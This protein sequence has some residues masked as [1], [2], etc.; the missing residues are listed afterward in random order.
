MHSSLNE[1]TWVIFSALV[2]A[3][4]YLRVSRWY[5]PP[6]VDTQQSIPREWDVEL[7]I[8]RVVNRNVKPPEESRRNC[9]DQLCPDSHLSPLYDPASLNHLFI[10]QA[11]WKNETNILY[12]QF[13]WF[14]QR[15]KSWKKWL[16]QVFAM[17]ICNIS[18]KVLVHV[19]YSS[20]S[21]SVWLPFFHGTQKGD[22]FNDFLVALF[23]AITM[24][25]DWSFK[26]SKTTQKHH[27]IL[28][29][30][31]YMAHTQ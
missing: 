24:I 6:A 1:R 10:C 15:Q 12:V 11:K 31:V 3:C 27:K 13:P 17:C 19:I 4:D 2:F 7:D 26:A 18:Y 8:L 9:L 30:I 25:V 5:I 20:L 21:K 16:D 29:E 22:I 14:I 28:I 23:N